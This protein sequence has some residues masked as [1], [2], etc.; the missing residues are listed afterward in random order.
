MDQVMNDASWRGQKVAQ[1]SK[2][3]VS[4]ASRP[5]GCKLL[6]VLTISKSALE[7]GPLFRAGRRPDPE[8]VAENSRGL[9]EANPP[10]TV[11][12]DSSTLKGCQKPGVRRLA[13]NSRHPP[14]S[15]QATVPNY[16]SRTP[17][18]CGAKFNRRTGGV[19]SLHPR[20][21]SATPSGSR[22]ARWRNVQTPAPTSNSAECRVKVTRR[23][24]GNLR[25]TY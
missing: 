16:N 1:V 18:G 22:R 3:A 23:G 17:S 2:P 10:V 4:P 6:A 15:G 5:C 12:F 13:V 24:F 9:S 14:K 19:A 8:G 21:L 25:H 20:L 7:F 11:F